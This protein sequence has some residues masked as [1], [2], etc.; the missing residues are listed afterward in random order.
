LQKALYLEPNFVLAHFA[1]GILAQRQGR[2]AAAARHFGNALVLL[3]RYDENTVLP[4]SDGMA[5]GQLKQM[6]EAISPAEGL[7]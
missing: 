5:A 1:I 4:H 7:A 2:Q 3:R 6:I